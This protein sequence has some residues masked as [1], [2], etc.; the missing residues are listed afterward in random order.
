MRSNGRAFQ[1]Q[2]PNHKTQHHD[3][4][5]HINRDSDRSSGHLL[6]RVQR[7]RDARVTFHRRAAQGNSV[8]MPAVLPG[9]NGLMENA[10]LED[11]RQGIGISINQQKT[12][13]RNSRWLTQL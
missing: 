12:K 2:T 3:Q 7:I 6:L 10:A 9:A 13:P 4:K 8:A 5:I 11:A 1:S